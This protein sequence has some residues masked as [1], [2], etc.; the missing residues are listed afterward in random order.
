MYS[1]YGFMRILLLFDL[2]VVT[3]QQ[4]KIYAKFRKSLLKDGFDMI[5]FSV[6][7][8]ICNGLEMAQRYIK[9]VESYAP[10]KGAVRAILMTE[11]QFKDMKIITG[12]LT[13]SEKMLNEQQYTLF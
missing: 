7:Q 6:Y 13:Y 5:Q 10:K 3:K 11:K 2:P 9:K 1:Y 4:R 8:R 12:T